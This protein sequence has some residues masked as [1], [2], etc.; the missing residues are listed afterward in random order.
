MLSYERRYVPS[1]ER[2][3]YEF[4]LQ[5]RAEGREPVDND[6]QATD[7]TRPER[8]ESVRSRIVRNTQVSKSLKRRYSN[9]CQVCGDRREQ[10][11]NRGYSGGHHLKPLGAPH[12]GLDIESNVVVLCPDHHADFDYGMI[13]VDPSTLVI[14]HK[15]EPHV[16]G[17]RLTIREDHGLAEEFLRYHEKHIAANSIESR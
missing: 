3:V 17:T 13:G 9:T 5:R 8:I 14:R 7:I 6:E 1:E 12:N 2:D 4:T 16:S 15:Y 10:S 11:E